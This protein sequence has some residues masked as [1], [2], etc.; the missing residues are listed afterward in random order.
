MQSFVIAA[1]LALAACAGCGSEPP[2]ACATVETACAPLY[3]TTS[4]ANVYSQTIAQD[5]GADK[6]ACHS[7]SGASGLSLIGEQQSFDNLARYITPGDPGCSEF[8]VRTSA[9]GKDYQMPQ[10]APLIESEQCALRK[11]VEAGAP[12]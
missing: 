9:P 1:A 7:A 3:T 2:P 6:G 8:V 12:R 5:C 10:G 11:W 4:Y